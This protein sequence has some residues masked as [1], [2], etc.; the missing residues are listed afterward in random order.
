MQEFLAGIDGKR[1][2]AEKDICIAYDSLAVVDCLDLSEVGS[3][4]LEAAITK[5]ELIYIYIIIMHTG[6]IDM[7][8]EFI[9]QRLQLL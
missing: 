6:S 8:K 9:M 5:Y 4:I 2:Q 1:L 7:M 3:N